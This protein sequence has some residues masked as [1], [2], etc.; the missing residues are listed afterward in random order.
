LAFDRGSVLVEPRAALPGAVHGPA[1]GAKRRLQ[2]GLARVVDV[3]KPGGAP[4]GSEQLGGLRVIGEAEHGHLELQS[5][6][7]CMEARGDDDVAASDR[8]KEV[9][10]GPNPVGEVLEPAEIAAPALIE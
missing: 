8:R 2:L 9:R 1:H 5:Q 7:H 4:R 10:D 6:Q 3:E